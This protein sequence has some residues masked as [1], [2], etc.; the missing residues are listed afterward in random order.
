MVLVLAEALAVPLRERNTLLASAGFAAL[1]VERRLSDAVLAPVR[2]ACEALLDKHEPLPAFLFDRH[3]NI[4]SANQASR[5]LLHLPERVEGLNIVR[6]LA[7]N[8]A[9]PQL[10]SNWVE[11]A[12]SMLDRLR[13]EARTFGPDPALDE[14]MALVRSDP[15]LRQPRPVRRTGDP[16]IGSRIHTPLG[17]VVLFSTLAEFGTVDDITVRELRVELFF[18]ADS[19]SGRILELAAQP[20]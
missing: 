17:E 16:F 3:W 10:V 11:V 19:E 5:R 7:G 4:L 8:P 9:A 6:L 2:A 1:Y 20:R 14:L 13:L 18:P 12:H 15:A